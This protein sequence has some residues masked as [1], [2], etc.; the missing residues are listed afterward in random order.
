MLRRSEELFSAKTSMIKEKMS[1]LINLF[2][3]SSFTC[4]PEVFQLYL[5]HISLLYCLIVYH[6]FVI[7]LR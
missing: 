7:L 6:T 2:K 5:Y 1:K 4:V 3:T